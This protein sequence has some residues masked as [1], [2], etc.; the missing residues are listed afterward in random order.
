[1]QIVREF[2]MRRPVKGVGMSIKLNWN[3]ETNAVQIKEIRQEAVR[4]YT[5]IGSNTKD[6][7]FT[8]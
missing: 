6:G 8:Y 3:D 2:W 1:M 5:G 4:F 7:I